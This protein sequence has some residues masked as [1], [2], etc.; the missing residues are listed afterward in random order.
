LGRLQIALGQSRGGTLE[1]PT[2]AQMAQLDIVRNAMTSIL[3]EI[4]QLA[5]VEVRDVEAAAEAAG[6]P[7]TAGRLPQVPVR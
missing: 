5:D 4:R 6:I 7:W 3:T 2:P 1:A